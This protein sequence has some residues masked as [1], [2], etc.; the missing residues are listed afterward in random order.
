[1]KTQ[2]LF[3]LLFV[4]TLVARAAEDAPKETPPAERAPQA[5]KPVATPTANTGDRNL[6]FNFRG[7]PLDMVLNYLS[8]A[9]GFIIVLETDVK[10]KV[11]AWSNQPLNKDE[12][13]DLLNTVLNKNGYS[14]IRNGRTLRI[15]S[16]KEAKTKD[17][18]VKSGNKPE[19]IP[20][21]DQMIT[22]VIPVMHASATQLVK[23]LQPLLPEYAQLSANESGNALVLTDVQSSVHRMV[24]IVQAL[25]TSIQNVL[26]IKV[27]PLKFADAKELANAVKEL[28]A[29]PTTQNQGNNNR[30]QF[31]N[32]FGG[33]G[34]GFPG[35]GGGGGQGGRG[36]NAAAAGGAGGAPNARVLAVADERT[37]SL[38]VSAP[39]EAME[40][41]KQLVNEVD[42]NI[43]DVTELRVFRLQNSDPLEM[44]D[45]FGQLFPDET[46]ANSSNNQQGGP[47]GNFRFGA[48]GNN[49]NRR[50]NQ[51]TD[52]SQRALKRDKVL[53]V[54]DART[55]SLIVT[56]SRE[57]MPDIATMIQQLDSS[58]ARK[59]KVYVYS[60]DNAD[61]N[62]V[63][64]VVRDMFERTTTTANRNQQNQTSALDTR[65]RQ[66]QNQ[67]STSSASRNQGF[68]AGNGQG[69]SGT[70]R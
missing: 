19:D 22:Q 1:M 56:A 70:F 9:A 35:F 55:S 61:V 30:N 18:P 63:A 8:E 24:E 3:S 45:L 36:G 39:E 21:T 59:Q 66:L 34:G 10:G 33:G 62:D 58:P 4:L 43:A 28:F 17:L 42:V 41:I 31:V 69:A 57:M 68:G 40:Q 27:F 47:F 53:A 32:R 29:P 60:L 26:T 65:N 44:A 20:K 23:D 52:Q 25:D 38:L 48:F 5:E 15:V 50:S 11:D 54:A 51:T 16:Q 14:A 46:R 13:V 67:G 12:A 64:Q 6:R 49:N 2:T 37:N 7:V